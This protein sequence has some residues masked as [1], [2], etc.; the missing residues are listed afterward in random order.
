MQKQKIFIKKYEIG[1]ACMLGKVVGRIVEESNEGSWGN[2]N[3]QKM[4]SIILFSTPHGSIL[5]TGILHLSEITK[6][7]LKKLK[8][9]EKE[10]KK[11]NKEMYAGMFKLN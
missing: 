1:M 4:F 11:E 10:L 3:G 8:M 2:I 9:Y 7:G 5:K 6:S